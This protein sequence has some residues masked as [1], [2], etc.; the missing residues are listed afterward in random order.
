[1]S[2]IIDNEN[3]DMQQYGGGLMD[4]T[5]HTDFNS[6]FNAAR[7]QWGDYSGG[8]GG[9]GQFSY[10]DNEYSTNWA[11]ENELTPE[12]QKLLFKQQYVAGG[13]G[14]GKSEGEIELEQNLTEDLNDD[15]TKKLTPEELLAKKR[16]DTLKGQ[17][18]DF[19]KS[20]MSIGQ[21]MGDN[22]YEYKM[23]GKAKNNKNPWGSNIY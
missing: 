21:N 22:S 6:A 9:G 12:Q 19:G 20:L 10:G 2:N 17:A 5:G 7:T 8:S 23:M 18:K 13:D 14:S 16:K 1:M 15:G 3:A 11:E 4:M